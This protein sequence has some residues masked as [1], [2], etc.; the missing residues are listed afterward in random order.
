M[1]IT[2]VEG[3]LTSPAGRFDGLDPRARRAATLTLL[4]RD[5]R[6]CST[7]DMDELA[8]ECEH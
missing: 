4:I 7:T 1:T 5:I 6:G 3:S 8:F 2:T